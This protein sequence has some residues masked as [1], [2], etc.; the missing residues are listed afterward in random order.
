MLA[1]SSGSQWMVPSVHIT[2][3][4]GFQSRAPIVHI[5]QCHSTSVS[6]SIQYGSDTPPLLLTMLALEN[7]ED[8]SSL[9]LLL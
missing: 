2:Q 8:S 7:T 6:I 1:L 3:F 5:T 9:F 4:G